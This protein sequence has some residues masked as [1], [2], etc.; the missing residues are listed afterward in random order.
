M[1]KDWRE[2]WREW[3]RSVERNTRTWIRSPVEY[4]GPWPGYRTR[5]HRISFLLVISR[6][7][8][9]LPFSVH[10]LALLSPGFWGRRFLRGFL[11]SRGGNKDS[12]N[13]PNGRKDPFGPWNNL[14]MI[15]RWFFLFYYYEK[16]SLLLR[17]SFPLRVDEDFDISELIEKERIFTRRDQNSRIQRLIKNDSMNRVWRSIVRRKGNSILRIFKISRR[18]SERRNVARIFSRVWKVSVSLTRWQIKLS[19][20][21]SHS[22]LPLYFQ[23][24]HGFRSNLRS[25]QHRSRNLNL[26]WVSLP[27]RLKLWPAGQILT[28]CTAGQ[29]EE[30]FPPWWRETSLRNHFKY[31][32][33]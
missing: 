16:T 28:L 18:E 32:Q 21:H 15:L 27:E 5:V 3:A 26:P 14:L 24:G 20:L 12:A 19:D 8:I 22:S 1:A 2:S 4:R 9:P 11:S 13:C 29:R 31:E 10:S 6:H 30:F 25:P 33:P 7:L 23:A 17:K